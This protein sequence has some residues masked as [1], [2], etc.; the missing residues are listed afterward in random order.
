MEDR[1]LICGN[2][3]P[4]GTEVCPLCSRKWLPE[5]DQGPEKNRPIDKKKGHKRKRGGK[6]RVDN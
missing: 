3:I 2:I 6:R 4:E 5:E 1:C